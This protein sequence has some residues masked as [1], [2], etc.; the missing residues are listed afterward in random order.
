[1][2]KKAVGLPLEKSG[3]SKK[4]QS[5]YLDGK[6]AIIVLNLQKSNWDELYYVNFGIWLKAFGTEQFPHF[7]HCHMYYRVERLFPDERE[8]IITGC[9][10]ARSNPDNLANLSLFIERRL[11]PFALECTEEGKLRELMS[12]GLLKGGLVRHEAKTYLMGN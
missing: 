11:I 1:M 6:D 3:F 4:G 10:L 7:N 2:F 5:W 8:L 9:D 12:G